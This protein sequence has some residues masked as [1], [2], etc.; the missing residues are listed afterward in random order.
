MACALLTAPLVLFQWLDRRTPGV[1]TLTIYAATIMAF[2][3]IVFAGLIGR[4]NLDVQSC[5]HCREQMPFQALVR[6]LH[7][8]GFEDGTILASDADLGGNLRLYYPHARVIAESYPVHQP[9]HPRNA[10]CLVVWNARR[11]GDALPEGLKALMAA[12]SLDPPASSPAYVDA[13]MLGS[14]ARMDR[15]AY[16]VLNDHDGNCLPR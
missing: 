1:R 15:F 8:A 13:P 4:A 3:V 11:Q 16:W 14:A 9:A 6:D 10:Q 7:A 2:A 5:N 12:L